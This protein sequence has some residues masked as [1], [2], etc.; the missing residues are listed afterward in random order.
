MTTFQPIPIT[1]VD[2]AV[3]AEQLLSLEAQVPCEF[4]KLTVAP[5]AVE[6]CDDPAA[7]AI[8]LLHVGPLCLA[9]RCSEPFRVTVCAA[10]LAA[11]VTTVA[12]DILT[13]P[14]D[15]YLTCAACDAHLHVID[16]IV[17][18]VRKL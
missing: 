18:E 8:G 4:E 1:T 3:T 5:G 10:H 15:R 11:V 2:P 12:S 16:D 6:R 13:A 7:W 17:R 14:A 9:N